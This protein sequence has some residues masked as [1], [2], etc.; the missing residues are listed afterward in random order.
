M[1]FLIATAT[2]LGMLNAAVAADLPHPQPPP[3][4]PVVGKAPIG[5]MPIGKGQDEGQP[6][7]AGRVRHALNNEGFFDAGV[8]AVGP[9][10]L[11]KLRKIVNTDPLTAYRRGLTC[12]FFGPS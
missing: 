7:G 8:S 9:S 12:T 1:K 11:Q 6:A 4:Q 3:P 10:A 2:S 5:K